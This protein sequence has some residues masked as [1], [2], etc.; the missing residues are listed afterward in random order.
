MGKHGVW[1]GED[2]HLVLLVD[3][4]GNYYYEDRRPVPVTPD[5]P[6]VKK[7]FFSCL[8]RIFFGKKKD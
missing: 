3:E 2:D 8:S 7:S 4:N 1:W 6:V 5:T